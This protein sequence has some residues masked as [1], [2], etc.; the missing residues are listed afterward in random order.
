M[1]VGETFTV[2]LNVTD[3]ADLYTY[4]IVFKYNQTMLNMTNLTF[5]SD[6]VF[7]GQSVIDSSLTPIS[8]TPSSLIDQH[9]KLGVAVA[10]QTLLGAV[11]VDVSN[12]LLFQVNFTAAAAGATTI[13]ICTT[14]NPA[15]LPPP[16]SAVWYTF[17]MNSTEAFYGGAEGET[18]NF[19][20]TNATVMVVVGGG[21][22]YLTLTTTTGGTTNPQPGTYPFINNSQVQVTAS[23]ELGYDFSNWQLDGS[24]AG[25]TNPINIT[26][27]T[28]HTLQ[29]VFNPHIPVTWTV[30]SQ[31]G[32]NFTTIQD[33]F[34]NPL[35]EYGDVILVKPGVYYENVEMTKEVTL[36]GTDPDNT[37]IDGNGTGTVVSVWGNLT[38]FT[39]R[40]GQYG[41][42]IETYIPGQ[43]AINE[44]AWINGNLI[45]N[46]LI[47]GVT[48]GS[49][50]LPY[51][52][53]ENCTV[54]NNTVTNNTL[55]GIHIANAHSDVIVNNT[56]ENNEYGIDFY[57]DS[58]NN[59]LTNNNMTDNKYNF[60]YIIRGDTIFPPNAPPNNVDPSNT[61]NGKPIY[62]WTNKNDTQ[63]PTDAGYIFLYNCTDITID[64][65]S[66]ANN[67]EGILA[68]TSNNTQIGENAITSN[69]YGIYLSWSQN[70]TLTG[71]NLTDNVYGVILGA[72]SKHT[73]MRNNS[74]SGGQFNFGMDT[75]FLMGTESEIMSGATS[76]INNTSL[77]N[78]ID[79][80][81]TLDGK[82]MVYWIDQ[83]DAQVPANAGFVML[84]NC[85][86][87]KVEGLNLANNLENILIFASNN[88]DVCNNY[89]ANSV[90]GVRA[91][92]LS[93]MNFTI[94]Q[95]VYDE[96]FNL[97]VS[98]NT[99]TNNGIGL[100]LLQAENST[101]SGNTLQENP[102]G[103][104]SEADYT[105]I[106]RNSI[107]DS[108]VAIFNT[109]LNNPYYF[110]YP[111]SPAYNFA[112]E[113]S[114]ELS[115]LA[116][117]GIIITGNNNTIYGNTVSNSG[118]SIII[119]YQSQQLYGYGNLI[120]HNN[121]INAT[122]QE[123]ID[124]NDH[125]QWDNGYP[126]G[127]NYWS[128]SNK[129]D[130]Y[131]GPGQNI[132]GSD[133]ICDT[134]YPI[135]EYS[136]QEDITV[137]TYD[138]YPLTVP[139]NIYEAA[140]CNST[141]Y[142]VDV[143]SNSTISNFIFNWPSQPSISFTVN[144]PS[145]TSGFCKVTIPNQVL[146]ATG[147]HWT[148]LLN[149]TQI[150]YNATEDTSFTYIYFNYSHS[151]ENI[152]IIGT[153]AIPE[154]PPITILAMLIILA[155]AAALLTI[156]IKR[157]KQA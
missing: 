66:L 14:N 155:F 74:I 63:V 73:T 127:G 154:Y 134:P 69:A 126:A 92:Y 139:V 58:N 50:P 23:P 38:G 96:C 68:I 52:A 48:V 125:N 102:I 27:N 30:S 55:Y 18:D 122:I 13:Q 35:L 135:T 65:C 112:W 54:S 146:W 19:D 49:V 156:R 81:N 133:G 34:N 83:H 64:G 111:T 104:L 94:T 130:L 137:Y 44:N 60:G 86:D 31:G 84:I 147:G 157:K 98:N 8:Q 88:T 108:N 16:G 39:I 132:T 11:G 24:N 22:T 118:F 32:A 26:M 144:G 119:G 141:E 9:D 100:E 152:Q 90:Y 17:A 43:S 76:D 113:Y 77:A 62:Y 99:L 12:G 85:T 114:K 61:V 87:I 75:Q 105:T 124:E 140:S 56:V 3:L 89:I 37:I 36:M 46:N 120:F 42:D 57:G 150:C 70:N 5:P 59:T 110:Y 47:G 143:Q 115:D 149:G 95:S 72:L 106:S 116:E 107:N 136:K 103:I 51:Q 67:I 145:G 101:L 25:S 128:D 93:Y 121:F 91:G 129:T 153:S 41:V 80:S 148:V 117:G 109:G 97:T 29:A 33:A 15:Y 21:A 7:A 142:D 71:N 79:T 82:P 151:T 1:N 2:A 28:N 45:I 20:L 53:T 4:Q 138:R 123:A 40:N 6:N 78:D 10:G 131:S